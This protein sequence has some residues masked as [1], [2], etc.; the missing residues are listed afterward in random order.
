VQISRLD[1]QTLL[2]SGLD[3]FCCELLRQIPPS[4]EVEE[5]D[6]AYSRLYPSPTAGKDRRLEEDWKDYVTPELR[7]LFQSSMEIVREDLSTFPSDE[8]A[9]EYSLHIPVKHLKAWINAMNQARLALAARYNV[10]ERD[11]EAEP[12]ENNARALALFQIHFYGILQEYFLRE[13]D[14]V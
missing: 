10:T 12:Q 3:V 11:M 7:E 13:S 1:E 5:G 2:L 9:M 14:G 8:P 4:A 6:A